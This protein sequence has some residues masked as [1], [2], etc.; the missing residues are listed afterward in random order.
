VNHNIYIFLLACS[1]TVRLLHS[2]AVHLLRWGWVFFK[3]CLQ[4]DV[5]RF[6]RGLAGLFSQQILLN[7]IKRCNNQHAENF[8][9]DV[10]NIDHKLFRYLILDL[11]STAIRSEC[12]PI[13]RQ[14]RPYSSLSVILS[15]DIDRD[16]RPVDKSV[17]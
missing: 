17:D 5:R 9:G 10:D 13:D 4:N 6:G 3:S 1:A 11:R 8:T 2:W 12:N 7:W 14:Y 15:T 16:N